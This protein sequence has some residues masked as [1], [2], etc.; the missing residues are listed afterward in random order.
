MVYNKNLRKMRENKKI[1]NKIPTESHSILSIKKKKS[2]AQ[3]HILKQF[4]H[5]TFKYIV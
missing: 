4:S 2:P 5:K 3:E 1:A